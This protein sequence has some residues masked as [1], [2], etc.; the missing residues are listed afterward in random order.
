MKA[1]WTTSSKN[2][3]PTLINISNSKEFSMLEWSKWE[4]NK[5]KMVYKDQ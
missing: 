3:M 5:S 2:K 4:I 1:W